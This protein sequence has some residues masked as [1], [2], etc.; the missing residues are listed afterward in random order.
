MPGLTLAGRQRLRVR[1]QVEGTSPT[2]I[3]RE[4][5]AR[6][7]RR[8]RHLALTTTDATAALQAAG[9]SGSRP[10]LSSTVDQRLTLRWD[11]LTARDRSARSRRRRTSPPTA[12]FTCDGDGPD[13]VA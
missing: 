5:V 6:R 11:D 2:T 1:V 13:G 10:T 8:A 4:G 12:S 7:H 9:G 3:R